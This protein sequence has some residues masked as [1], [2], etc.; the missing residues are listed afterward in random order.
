MA[1]SPALNS[2]LSVVELVAPESKDFIESVKTAVAD[3]KISVQEILD[4]AGKL[5]NLVLQH[6]PAADQRYGILAKDALQAAAILE[7]AVVRFQASAPAP[8]PSAPSA[9]KPA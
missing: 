5:D 2:A 1:L 3:G 6:L 7:N 9:P 4:S 8:A